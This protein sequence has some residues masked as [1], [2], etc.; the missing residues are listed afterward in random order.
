MQLRIPAKAAAFIAALFVFGSLFVADL[1]ARVHLRPDVSAV[2]SFADKVDYDSHVLN[3][4][5][6][7]VARVHDANAESFLPVYDLRHPGFFLL[8]AEMFV[9][10]GADTPL[11][12]QVLS[13]ALYNIGALC[14]FLWVFLLFDDLLTAT[15]AALFLIL[16]P[17]FLSFPGMIQTFPFEFFFFNLTMLIFVLWLRLNR[18]ALLAAA[19]AAMFLTCMNYWFYYLSTWLIMVGLFWQFCGCPRLRDVALISAPPLLA[20]SITILIVVWISGGFHAGTMRLLEM[21]AARTIDARMSGGG[22]YPDQHFLTAADWHNYPVFFFE[23]LKQS[24]PIMFTKI[25]WYVISAACTI[26]S[27]GFRCR[28]A[29]ISLGVLLVGGL[30]WYGVMFQHTMMHQFSGQ[31]CFMAICPLFGL[32][33]SEPINLA[34]S[35]WENRSAGNVALRV[36]HCLA[37]SFLIYASVRMA[38]NTVNESIDAVKETAK[39]ASIVEAKYAAAIRDICQS[40]QP[41]VTL[42]DL[43]RASSDWGFEWRP[44]YISEANRL[45][46]CEAFPVLHPL[47]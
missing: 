47:D 26:A 44:Q 8:V 18:P 41:A 43:E 35:A 29:A 38:R 33:I 40:G 22:Y 17:F 31:Y 5:K 3:L 25:D 36:S 24:Y 21:L 23:R 30:A 27:L 11:P 32:M 19:L 4:W 16:S 9:R 28:R 12:L 2:A 37:A 39:I 45:P 15:A 46:R 20:A 42:L 13:I 34:L 10:A 6:R 1:V 14:F 7:A